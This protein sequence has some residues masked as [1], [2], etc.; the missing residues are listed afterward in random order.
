MNSENILYEDFMAQLRQLSF[1]TVTKVLKKREDLCAFRMR[2]GSWITDRDSSFG[3]AYAELTEENRERAECVYRYYCGFTEDS[4]FFSRQTR[5]IKRECFMSV[6]SVL[7]ARKSPPVVGEIIFG[8]IDENGT[9]GRRFFWWNFAIREAC[10]FANLL[11]RRMTY[12]TG[13]LET[14]LVIRNREG[15]QDWTLFLLAKALHFRDVDYFV[16]QV[17]R[18][19][20]QPPQLCLK[21][22][23]D[24]WLWRNVSNLLPKFYEEFMHKISARELPREMSVSIP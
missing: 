9:E 3:A 4:V 13:K 10:N 11:S 14:K 1:C 15:P 2:D 5:S 23:I 21:C 18:F 16:E 6:S 19:G 7:S 17:Q 8:H 12:S 22:T 20:K 24:K